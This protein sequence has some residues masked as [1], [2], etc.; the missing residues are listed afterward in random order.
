MH[1][2]KHGKKLIEE[3]PWREERSVVKDALRELGFYR[4]TDHIL[5]LLEQAEDMTERAGKPGETACFEALPSYIPLQD[6]TTCS[7]LKLL[8]DI[9]GTSTKAGVCVPGQDRW[10]FLFDTKNA[11]MHA[12]EAG[13]SLDSFAQSLGETIAREV[14]RDG[15]RIDKIEHVGFVWSNAMDNHPI[16]SGDCH[17]V[18]GL[19]VT[20]E[21]Y[22]KNE[23]FIR[24][25]KNGRDLGK[26]FLEGLRRA[27]LVHIHTLVIGNDAALT[28]KASANADAG[29]V[30][31]TGLNATVVKRLNEIGGS[32]EEL[33]LCNAEMGGRFPL[34]ERYLSDADMNSVQ[35]KAS[36]VEKVTAGKFL[37]QVYAEHLVRLYEMGIPGLEV[38]GEHLKEIGEE[39]F[40]AFRARDV[41]LPFLP[42]IPLFLSRRSSPEKFPES[43]M[44]VLAE[45]GQEMYKRSAR[46][47]AL[48]A[49]GSICNRFAEKD[50]F[51]LSL[52]S[53]LAREIP[54]FQEEFRKAAQAYMPQGKRLEIR[55][56]DQLPVEDGSISVPMLGAARALD[57]L[58]QG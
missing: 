30:A 38:P 54:L 47:C 9:G 18:T 17:G 8:V 27:G 32:G 35:D 48:L 45:I 50:A 44:P 55:L 14:E 29:M 40:A 10:S 16:Q 49:Y 2:M 6:K 3:N 4:A 34:A 13:D 25:I 51:Q 12:D 52:D 5:E 33:V 21:L 15:F 53:R 23:W 57:A 43:S 20:R 42:D 24:D 39:R 36:T 58:A 28:A 11:E 56:V 41:A 19:V 31:S 7:G 46:L 1:G 26:S 22:M 37:P